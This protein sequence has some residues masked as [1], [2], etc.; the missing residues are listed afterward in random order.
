MKN[1]APMR[2]A[3]PQIGARNGSG[4]APREPPVVSPERARTR[5]RQVRRRRR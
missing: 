2:M 3:N 1:D 5:D 4:K